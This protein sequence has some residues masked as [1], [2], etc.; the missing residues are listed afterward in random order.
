MT[1]TVKG[2]CILNKAE[3]DA[4]VEKLRKEYVKAA[5]CCPDYL[6][7][8][9]STSCK[10]LDWMKNKLESRFLGEIPIISDMQMTTPLLQKVEN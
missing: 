1:H 6:T 4:F 10:I 2:F 9:Q 5:Y 3:V 7:H 8:M